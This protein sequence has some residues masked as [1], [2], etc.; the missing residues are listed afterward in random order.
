M[1]GSG[2]IQQDPATDAALV[3]PSDSTD[4]PAAGYPFI[5]VAGNLK[6][7]T[8]AGTAIV[9]TAVPVGLLPLRVKRIW[10]AGITATV[11]FLLLND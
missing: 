8:H 4:L 10:A 6:V 11:G 3:T 1:A 5:T 9:L 2:V 7:T